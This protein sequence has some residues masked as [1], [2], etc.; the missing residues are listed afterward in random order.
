MA[1]LDLADAATIVPGQSAEVVAD[2]RIF[3]V[4][5]VDGV[6]HVIDGICPHAGGPLG[7]GTLRGNIVTC[8]WHGW[9]FNVSSGQHCLNQRICQTA[10]AVRIE[11]GRVII[12]MPQA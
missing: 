10:Y 11:N 1:S 7:K 3:A 9:Q 8:P 6:F 2:G 4:Y 12:D 5:N